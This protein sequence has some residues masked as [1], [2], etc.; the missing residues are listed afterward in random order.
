MIREV[1]QRENRPRKRLYTYT[2]PG[3]PDRP[4]GAK[5]QR[6]AASSPQCELPSGLDGTAEGDG[7]GE[8]AAAAQHVIAMFR[9][10]L[11]AADAAACLQVRAQ[12][13]SKL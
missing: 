2:Y 3:S 5:R 10:Q 8:Q 4:A 7:A 11:A 6:S 13:L 12:R 1:E 9:M